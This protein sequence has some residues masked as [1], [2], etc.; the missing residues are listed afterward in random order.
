MERYSSLSFCAS[1][2]AWSRLCLSVWRDALPAHYAGDLWAAVQ[3][4]LQRP[5]Y[6]LRL[7]PQ[8]LQ[9]GRH[10]AVRLR[11]Q[12]RQHVLGR[13]LLVPQLLRQGLPLLER[14]LRP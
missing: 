9:N 10:N 7:R 12:R 14:F 11:H 3:L 13:D 2:Q 4:L 8:L 6:L 5:G 1:F